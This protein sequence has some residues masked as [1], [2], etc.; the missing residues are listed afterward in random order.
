V[1]VFKNITRQTFRLNS[2]TAQYAGAMQTTA[3]G[4]ASAANNGRWNARWRSM[5]PTPNHGVQL[6]VL[7]GNQRRRDDLQLYR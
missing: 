7:D 6:V 2:L 4:C 3:S 5:S 1:S